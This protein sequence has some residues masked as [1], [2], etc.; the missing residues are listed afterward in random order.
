MGAMTSYQSPLYLGDVLKQMNSRFC[1]KKTKIYKE[2]DAT[3]NELLSVLLYLVDRYP[4]IDEEVSLQQ[5]LRIVPY[6]G[7]AV[8]DDE[9]ALWV[10]MTKRLCG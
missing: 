9:K 10:T 1:Y 7:K 3:Q 6:G 8:D 5:L 2:G 4:T